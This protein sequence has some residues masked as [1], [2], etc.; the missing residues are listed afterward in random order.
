MVVLHPSELSALVDLV[1]DLWFDVDQLE[2]HPSCGAAT[3][4]LYER[5]DDLR[6][7]RPPILTLVIKHVHS[8]VVKDSE[9][10][11]YYDI[12]QIR[13]DPVANV[14]TIS[15][16]IPLVVQFRVAKLHIE[17][18]EGVWELR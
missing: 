14:L 18:H 16:C 3:I 5:P 4:P 8:A 1:H 9:H 15:G 6:Q 13:F 12:D 17:L 10:V 11:G 2:R 7:K